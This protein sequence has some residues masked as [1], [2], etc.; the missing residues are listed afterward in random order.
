MPKPTDQEPKVPSWRKPPVLFTDER[1][2]LFLEY[3]LENGVF[4]HAAAAAGV[5]STAVRDRMRADPNFAARVT[6]AKE[7]H[8]DR[9]VA[10]AVKL[11]LV[12]TKRPIVGGKDKDQIVA[13]ERIYSERLLELLL[14][15]RRE[16]FRC[17]DKV[18]DEGNKGGVMIT[19]AR[20]TTMDD[21]EQQHGEAAKG[22][23]GRPGGAK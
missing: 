9:L 23:T 1:A 5:E 4:Y 11:A 18:E 17:R 6:E 2:E 15:T 8:T 10:Q 20:P 19:P 14:K 12:G 3:Y 13:H 7:Q 22:N 16:E 21:W